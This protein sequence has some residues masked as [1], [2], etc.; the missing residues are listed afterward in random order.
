MAS[1]RPTDSGDQD[2]RLVVELPPAESH[3]LLQGLVEHLRGETDLVDEIEKAAPHEVVIT[4]DGRLLFAYALTR[5]AL[6]GARRLIESKL[7]LDGIVPAALRVSHWDEE[8][9]RWRQ[10]DPPP[11][12]REQQRQDDAD[13]EADVVQTRTLVATSA[14]PI[15]SEFEQTMSAWADKLGLECKIV[16]HPHLLSTQV[17]FTVT[18]SRH[19]LDEF[20]QGLRAEGWATIRTESAVML[21]P[22]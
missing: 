22:L 19:K 20:A 9:D 13:R 3:G 7:S 4:H 11:D 8:L 17:A 2:W 1:E 12:P 15:R 14:K 16:E 5:A 21:S 18:G 6:D 10:L